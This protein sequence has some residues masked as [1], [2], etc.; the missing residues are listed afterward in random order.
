LPSK[1][2]S[3]L[4]RFE[5]KDD[6]VSVHAPENWWTVKMR[7][8]ED[9]EKW[10]DK[11]LYVVRGTGTYPHR[12]WC[13]EGYDSEETYTNAELTTTRK[14]K[15]INQIQDLSKPL[16]WT[17]KHTVDENSDGSRTYRWRV[18]LIDFDQKS[19]KII[20]QLKRVD[21]RIEFE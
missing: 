15:S 3:A 5:V 13:R 4:A 20:N 16:G 6:L 17:G 8:P 12:T 18:R 19:G 11:P 7:V 9:W 21:Y 14:V 2:R 10:A 1:P